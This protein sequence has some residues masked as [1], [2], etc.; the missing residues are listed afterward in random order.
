MD[1]AIRVLYVGDGPE[2]A[3]EGETALERE[4]DR[5]TV[6]AAASA[7]DAVD[8]FATNDFDCV[9]TADAIPDGTGLELLE[10]VRNDRPDLPFI[11]F[12]DGDDGSVASDAISAG[13][14]DYLRREEGY[15]CLADRICDTVDDHRAR[16][17]IE[18]SERHLRQVYERIT[19]GFFA[20][21]TDWEY[22]YVNEEGAR[23]VDRSREELLG[24][25]VWDAFPD[26][27]DSPFGDALRT[28]MESQETV[29]VEEYYPAHDTWYDVRVYPADDGIS[30]YFQDVTERKEDERELETR[31][32]QQEI[33]AELGRSALSDTELESLFEHAVREAAA[34]LDIEYAKVLDYRPA[35]DDL[36]LRAG[37][38]WDE[39]LVGDATVGVGT[40]SQAGYTLQSAEP[41]IVEDLGAGDR[42]SGPPL[43]TEHGVTSGISV[44]VGTTD[45][46]WGV[47]GTYTTDHRAFTEDDVNFVQS[48]ANVLANAI[49]NREREAEL[50]RQ[51]ERLEEFASV[52]SHDLRSP[53]NVAQG[54]TEL[55][56][57]EV[58]SEHLDD[59]AAALDRSLALIDDLLTL[60]REGRRASEVEPVDLATVIGQ[61]WQNIA[62][63]DATLVAETDRTILADPS[64]LRQ[65]LANLLR[66][67]VEHGS[68]SSRTRS[69]DAV[70]HGSTGN[71]TESGDAVEHGGEKPTVTVG[72]L[73]DGFYVADDGPGIPEDKRDRVFDAGY[74][75][76]DDGTGFGLNIVREIAEAHGW[77]VTA[78]EG[79]AGGARFEITGV[80]PAE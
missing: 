19:D 31:V 50:Q 36:L 17:V 6:E 52:V 73:E 63:A 57:E 26:L 44:V 45:D 66:N 69:D 5:L 59:V 21:N 25:T 9:V 49:E 28:A 68:T 27:A 37:V 16:R 80:E 70:E 64:Q 10:T 38:G 41:V 7:S 32:R 67:A 29:T 1:G 60:A 62:T 43:L 11:L 58:D 42:F 71:R 13:V 3:D 35:H 74:S 47:L 54:R 18:E 22:T 78:T 77:T 8:R 2:T 46:P 53:L 39:G 33:V 76:A 55:A 23:L 72:N 12:V 56:R 14:T 34:A 79:E 48:V 40:D 61:C 51:N 30:I 24:E 4:S 20:V 75:T 15:A 65:L